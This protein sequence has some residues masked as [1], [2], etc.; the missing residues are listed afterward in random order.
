MSAKKG[1]FSKAS[2]ELTKAINE[3]FGSEDNLMKM[4]TETE[5]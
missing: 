1:A 3:E 2:E 4:A 5:A